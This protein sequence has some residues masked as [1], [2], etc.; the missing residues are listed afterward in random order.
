MKL[1]GDGAPQ[2]LNQLARE[3][4]ITKLLTDIR[5]DLTVCELEGIDPTEYLARLHKEIAHFHP[6]ERMT[7]A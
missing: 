2:A 6:C 5:I 3:Q 1:T 7:N 4:M